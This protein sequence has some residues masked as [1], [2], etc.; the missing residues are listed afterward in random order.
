MVFLALVFLFFVYPFLKMLNFGVWTEDGFST[1]YF[2]ILGETRIQSAIRNTIWIA[3]FATLINTV[4]GVFF[5]W[6]VAY[7]DIRGKKLL[8]ILIIMPLIIPS[9]IVTLSWVEFSRWLPFGNIDLYSLGGI[10]FVMGI[11]HYTLVYLLSVNVLRRI[12][13]SLEEAVSTSGGSRWHVLFRVTIPL[14]MTGI[15]GGMIVA[16]LSNIENFG[17][18]AFLG[19]PGNVPVLSTAI[20][21]EVVSYGSDSFARGSILSFVLILITGFIILMQWLMMRRF[22]SNDE[23]NISHTPRVLLGRGRV[24]VEILVYGFLVVTSIVPLFAL[25][26]T[27][28]SPFYGVDL[29]FENMTFKNF[30]YVL[31]DYNSTASAIQNSF[32][33]AFLAALIGLVISLVIGYAIV[34]HNKWYHRLNEMFMAIPYSLPGT[35]LALSLIIFWIQPFPGVRPGVYSTF[36]ILLIAYVARFTILQV[37]AAVSSFNQIDLSLEQAAISSGAGW[38]GRWKSIIM[39][40]LTPGLI[41]GI[42]LVVFTALTEL[43]LSALLW[44]SGNETIGVVVFS[45]EQAGYKVYSSAFSVII[46]GILLVGGIIY[47]ALTTWIERRTHVDEN[48]HK[49]RS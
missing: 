28:L 46:I 24:W 20:Y 16:V 27:S 45:F 36:W 41:G 11:S 32:M 5:A 35:V 21:Q 9:Y 13:L 39:P 4:L 18:P 40:L 7:T 8:Q 14:G 29:T 44:S 22:R 33:L 42:L 31:F 23:L 30:E 38:F 12:P 3:I 47:Y 17:V 49:K 6:L 48:N 2:E 25:V 10:I 34:R 43:T 19:I 26:R 1:T 37:R 15:I